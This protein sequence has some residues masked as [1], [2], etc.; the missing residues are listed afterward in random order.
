MCCDTICS[1]WLHLPHCGAIS[2]WRGLPAPHWP[3]ISRGHS[4]PKQSGASVAS[5]LTSGRI[6][7]NGLWVEKVTILSL[8]S[9][10]RWTICC[11]FML[12]AYASVSICFRQIMF[13][14]TFHHIFTI[15]I[16]NATQGTRNPI[17][18]MCESHVWCGRYLPTRGEYN[19][20]RL[21]GGIESSFNDVASSL[22][23][24][25]QDC[26]HPPYAIQSECETTLS[27]GL[28]SYN[29]VLFRP[30]C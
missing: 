11:H 20:A 18:S 3:G 16:S 17:P 4:A 15:W 30:D 10:R 14:M 9:A 8:N 29:L 2:I 1:R 22:L 26:C 25:C 28:S 12:Q 21:R 23:T 5:A 13:Y 24:L 6:W 7:L 19:P 27:C